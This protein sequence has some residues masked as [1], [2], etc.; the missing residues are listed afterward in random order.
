M[1]RSTQTLPDD[2]KLAFSID[3]ATQKAIAMILNLVGVGLA[4][5]T[6]WLLSIISIRIHPELSGTF[7]G[8]LLP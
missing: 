4:F 7:S 3:L 1:G 2:Y 8:V 5:F 6:I